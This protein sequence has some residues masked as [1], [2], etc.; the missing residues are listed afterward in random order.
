MNRI[1]Y[2]TIITILLFNGC[3]VKENAEPYIA[4]VGSSI[5]S[6]DQFSNSYKNI[7]QLSNLSDSP[8]LRKMH[9]VKL[10]EKKLLAIAARN[11]NLNLDDYARQQVELAKEDIM[12]ELLYERTIAQAEVTIPDSML[13]KHYRWKNT[14]VKLRH[15]F[16]QEYSF[17]DS[18]SKLIQQDKVKF[19]HEA[20]LH[21]KNMELKKSGGH[22][23]WVPYDALDP[24][25]EEYAFSMSVGKISEP[26]Q[27]SYGWHILYKENEKYQ[28]F[29]DENLFQSQKKKL[30][31][32][33]LQKK[34]QIIADQ[35]VNKL[36]QDK[37]ISIN[38][39][40]FYYISALIE[41]A[42]NSK[43]SKSITETQQES[44]YAKLTDVKKEVL[45][46]IEE[47]SLTVDDFIIRLQTRPPNIINGNLTTGLYRIIRDII[48]VQKAKDLN[49][50]K[51]IKVKQRVKDVQDEY[52]ASLFLKTV[53]PRDSTHIQNTDLKKIADSLATI[54]TVK[55]NDALL[56][57]FVLYL[58]QINK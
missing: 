39:S 18:L 43:E 6:I 42:I 11:Q 19:I 14:E 33:I 51:N 31:I 10:V 55:Y 58:K 5:V 45:A 24:H 38:D 48:L 49:M 46:N 3:S 21:L 36:I 27:S 40:L 47:D 50:D 54:Y 29:I 56:D 2:I 52:Y 12:R 53:L 37:E 9:A 28:L 4:K 17:I 35:Y 32:N 30:R 44:I 20:K 26:I 23:G 13:R 22:L 7:I 8:E 15:I 34:R 16:H 1:L 57:T 25:L 41:Y